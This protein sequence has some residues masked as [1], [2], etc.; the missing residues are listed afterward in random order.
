MSMEQIQYKEMFNEVRLSD[1]KKKSIENAM[2]ESGKTRRTFSVKKVAI[3]AACMVA[4]ILC[5]C[6]AAG[7]HIAKSKREKLEEKGD[8][9][10]YDSRGEGI[11][12][13]ITPDTKEITMLVNGEPFQ[14]TVDVSP[15]V[16]ENGNVNMEDFCNDVVEKYMDY[17]QEMADKFDKTHAGMNMKHDIDKEGNLYIEVWTDDDPRSANAWSHMKDVGP[18]CLMVPGNVTFADDVELI[19]C[20]KHGMGIPLPEDYGTA[21]AKD[22][23]L[24][25]E[26]T[27]EGEEYILADMGDYSVEIVKKNSEDNK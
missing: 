8:I 3:M 9:I 12:N 23:I 11:P 16:D 20:G 10:T 17:F 25:F 5:V 6:I 13:K 21:K 24:Y 26:F 27:Y 15:F 7:N 4:V 14:W 18:W 1:D 19:D 2:M 22:E